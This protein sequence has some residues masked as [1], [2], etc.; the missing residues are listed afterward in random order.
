LRRIATAAV[1]LGVLGAC[2]GGGGSDPIA[3]GDRV[4]HGIG[5]CAICH[6]DALQGTTMGP[7]LLDARYGRS[8]LPDSAIEKAIHD[9]VAAKRTEYGPMP[10]R[11]EVSERQI[12]AVIA[13]IRSVQQEHGV[14]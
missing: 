7:A 10:R 2:G 13:Y 5:T 1:A 12:D 6:G 14:R 8:T 9:G 3:V 11:P 4:F